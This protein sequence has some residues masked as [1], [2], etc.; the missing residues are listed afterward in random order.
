MLP[1]LAQGA[2][3]AIE[4]GATL[5]I[6]LSKVTR[7]EEL[8]GTLEVYEKLRKPRS[9]ELQGMAIRQVGGHP[10]IEV[11]RWKGSWGKGDGGS[12]RRGGLN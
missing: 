1:Y 12:G 9:S 11:S 6:L 5:G 2:G 10:P 7:R 4:D 3:S 8:K